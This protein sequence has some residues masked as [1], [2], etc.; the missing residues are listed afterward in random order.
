MPKP[1]LYARKIHGMV[2]LF[3]ET[4]RSTYKTLCSN[5]EFN[6]RGFADLDRSRRDN[7]DCVRCITR[8]HAK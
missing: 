6:E 5:W 2:H 8:S 1:K 3:R 4:D 7:V